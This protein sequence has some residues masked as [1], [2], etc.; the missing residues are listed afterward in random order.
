[1][2]HRITARSGGGF[3]LVELLVTIAIIAILASLLLPALGKARDRAKQIACLGNIRT[4]GMAISNYASDYGYIIASS[5]PLTG[6]GAV[7]WYAQLRLYT[8]A[9]VRNKFGCEGDNG[10]PG[11]FYGDIR[12]RYACPSI[13]LED[14]PGANTLKAT[15]A[16]SVNYLDDGERYLKGPS[17][18]Q[19]S[20]LLILGDVIYGGS[21]E[22]TSLPYG[23]IHFRHGNGA[24]LL[25][26][27]MHAGLRVKGTFSASSSPFW[28]PKATY[29]NLPD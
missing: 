6:A 24:N 29:A 21:I 14:I 27:D 26:G 8:G 10:I 2:S 7:P 19:P 15:L 3:S 11:S 17:F 9:D 5:Y 20:R 12:D 4:F 16:P 13:R 1:M 23:G 28:S 25:Y 22:R 18:P